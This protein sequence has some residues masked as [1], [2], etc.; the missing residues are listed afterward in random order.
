MERLCCRCRGRSSRVVRTPEFGRP[1][2]PSIIGLSR[3]G[4]T[5]RWCKRSESSL[6]PATE[7]LERSAANGSSPRIVLKNSKIS[8]GRIS[9]RNISLAKVGLDHSQGAQSS[10]TIAGGWFRPNPFP[11]FAPALYRSEIYRLCSKSEFF[12]TIGSNPPSDAFGLFMGSEPG[13]CITHTV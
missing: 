2:Q 1:G 5:G 9:G 11:K 3:C 10:P 8:D 4:E 6:R 13:T 12:N 7:T